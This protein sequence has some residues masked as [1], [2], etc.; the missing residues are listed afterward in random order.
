ME[1]RLR[2]GLELTGQ[3]KHEAG[4]AQFQAILRMD[5]NHADAHYNLGI[6]YARQSLYTEAANE[7]QETLRVVPNNP[8]A[9]KNLQRARALAKKP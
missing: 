9:K 3:G 7:F 2:L 1:A 6:G 5:P 8:E 4:M